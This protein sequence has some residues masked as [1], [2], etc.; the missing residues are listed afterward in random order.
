M[1]QPCPIDINVYTDGSWQFPLRHY[2]ALGGNGVWWPGR[3]ISRHRV[4]EAE[5]ELSYVVQE[6]EGVTLC[7]NIG[8]FAGSSTRTEIA[9][10]LIAVCSHGAVHI[11][12]DS[13]VF[14]NEA[15]EIIS[16]AAL[17]D[18]GPKC[19]MVHSDGDFWHHFEQA[20]IAKGPRAVE[21][22]WVKGHATKD[23]ID[24][25]ITTVTR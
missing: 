21:L 11:G 16:K 9:A 23:H 19:W 17:G 13:E 15:N 22:T 14:V 7:T 18:V 24:R 4:R 6:C 25:G 3:D 5:L 1:L 10:V 12:S 8:G 20:I 2:F